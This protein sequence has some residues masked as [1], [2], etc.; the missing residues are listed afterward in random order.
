MTEN[1]GE[2]TSEEPWAYGPI[3]RPV[4]RFIHLPKETREFLEQLTREDLAHLARLIQEDPRKINEAVRF[5]ETAKS[6]GKFNAWLIGGIAGTI[7]AFAMLGDGIRKI[8]GW[9]K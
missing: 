6:V 4:D 1:A 7:I 9:I 2:D 3:N 8:M 5:Y